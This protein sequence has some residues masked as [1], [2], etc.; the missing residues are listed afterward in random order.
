VQLIAGLL[1]AGHETTTS[2]LPNFF[3]VLLTHPQEWQ[4]L[5]DDPALIPSAVEELMRYVPLGVGASIPR[6][7][8]EDVA[9]GDVIVKAGEP[10]LVALAA[11]NRD[12]DVFDRPD[13]LDLQRP[14]NPHIGFGHGAHHCVGAQLAR[15]DLQ[16]ALRVLIE[17]MPGLTPAVPP[18]ELDWKRGRLVRGLSALPVTW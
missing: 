18:E 8:L 15:L 1:A 17:R 10:V 12:P 9:F 2:Q 13:T 11:A 5:V 16:V 7:A 14:S 4:R 6:Y 3:Y